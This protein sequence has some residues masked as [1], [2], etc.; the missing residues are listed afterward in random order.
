MV[1]EMDETINP[2]EANMGWTIAWLPED[3]QFIGRE[4]LEKLRATGTDKLWV[5]LVMREK[6]VLRVQWVVP[7]TFTDDLG[8][9]REGVITSGTFHRHWALVLH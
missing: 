5:G 4:A 2:L 9:L 1:Q 8:E 6:G 3:R 7:C